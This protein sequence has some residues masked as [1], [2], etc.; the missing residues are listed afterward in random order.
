M[1]RAERSRG[2]VSEIRAWA[3]AQRALPESGLGRA[4]AYMLGI[5]KGLTLFLDDTRIPLDNN[6]AER[7]LRGLVVGRKNHYGSRSKRGTE[8]AALFYSLIESAKLAGV[9][10]K[11][12]LLKAVHAAIA[13][14]KAVTLPA[15]LL[16]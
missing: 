10:P 6:L 13:D 11:T 1:L 16:A 15:D 7:G 14:P 8:V 9:D 5:W 4:V 2:I 12:Y 3:F